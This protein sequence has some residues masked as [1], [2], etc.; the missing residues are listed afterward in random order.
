MDPGHENER[1]GGKA[2]SVGIEFVGV[3]VLVRCP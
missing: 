3:M 2:V 1:C